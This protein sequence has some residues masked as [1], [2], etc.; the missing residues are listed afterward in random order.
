MASLLAGVGLPLLLRATNADRAIIDTIR[1]TPKAVNRVKK[2]MGFKKGGLVHHTGSAK[3]HKG[4][5]VLTKA[6][7][8]KMMRVAKK[9]KPKSKAKSKSKK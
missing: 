7:V 9:I 6:Q 3:V 4:E 1:K 2:E 8:D 5:Y